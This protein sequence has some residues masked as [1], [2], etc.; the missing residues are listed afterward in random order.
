[1]LVFACGEG[2]LELKGDGDLD[3]D[4]LTSFPDILSPDFPTCH[5]FSY[6]S[7]LAFNDASSTRDACLD[8][9]GGG[10]GSFVGDPS[11]LLGAG[12]DSRVQITAPALNAACLVGEDSLAVLDVAGLVGDASLDDCLCSAACLNG[13]DSLTACLIGDDSLTACLTGDDSLPAFFEVFTNFSTFVGEDSF[14]K[15]VFLGEGSLPLEDGAFAETPGDFSLITI[16][17]F[18]G[19]DS[20]VTV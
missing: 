7:L 14:E 16:F 6:S 10:V 4:L 13:D 5:G 2:D 17:L 19:L 12:E 20:L 3:L 1:M 9:P 15:E 8:K 18:V 11:L